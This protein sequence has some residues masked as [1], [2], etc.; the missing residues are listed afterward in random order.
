MKKFFYLLVV[1]FFTTSSS[2]A[3]KSNPS[4]NLREDPYPLW[5]DTI[6]SQPEG[7]RMDSNGN[8]EISSS[9]GLVWLI[10]TVN[11]LNGCEP[12]D[13]DGCTVRL[14]N[15]IDFGEEG[16][17][18]CF[19]PIGT[20]ETP[21]LGTF[22]GNGHKIHHLLQRYSRYDG[23]DNYFFD[24][25]VFGYIRHATVKNVTLD[26]TCRISSS[27]DYPGFYRG[28]MVGFAD[29]L[30]IVDNIYIH[31]QG[32]AHSYGSSL[33]GMNRNSTVR[34]CACG[35]QNYYF[36]SPDEGAVLVD[37]NRCD[38]G[39]ADAIVENCYFYGGID[40]SYNTRYVGGLVHFN[41]TLPNNNGK[42]AILRN[43]H[44]TPIDEFLGYKGYGSFAVFLTEGSCI[45]YCYTDP[46]K[47]YQNAPMVGLNQGGDL[48]YCSEYTNIDGIGTLTIPVTINDT[49][50]DNLL[51]ALNLW[52]IE[53]EHPE[54]YRTWAIVNDSIPVFGDY[55]VGI[56]EN[57]TP[58]DMVTIH[59]NPTLGM[60]A[61]MGENLH[62]AAVVNMLGQQVL[63]VQ[64][65]DNELRI[66][67][68][69]LPAGIYFVAVTD[70]NGRKTVQKVVK[71]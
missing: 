2:F 8:V 64:G 5:T 31:S 65:E 44:S 17:N 26:S 54:L 63:M 34:N 11:G 12:N 28:G 38:G 25:G 67:M 24:M 55:Y 13:F 27:C 18:Y 32:I 59:P 41:E 20:R 62:Q 7:Y 69:A 21:F 37:Y 47:M 36:G 48:M 46:T 39:F 3:Q 68:T 40:W 53:Q 51:D 4:K 9:D 50:I 58:D 15:D 60:I 6:V 19:S 56:S 42:R 45:K 43:C 70:N 10:S 35:G 71:Q 22:D 52:I 23:I 30:S 61:I 14:A 66:D 49:T 33:V 1:L 57:P 16:L 29:S